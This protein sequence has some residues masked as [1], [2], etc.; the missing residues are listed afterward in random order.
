M[1]PARYCNRFSAGLFHFPAAIA[2][3][4]VVMR[5][6]LIRLTCADGM[7]QPKRMVA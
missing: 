4:I 3:R 5:H 6:W 1:K 2:C 7:Q